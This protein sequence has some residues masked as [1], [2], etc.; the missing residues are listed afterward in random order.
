MKKLSIYCVLIVLFALTLS[1]DVTQA[2]CAMCKAV[3]QSNAGSGFGSVVDGL[4][5]GILYLMTIPYLML[6][7][8]AVVFFRKSWMAKLKK[9]QQ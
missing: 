1:P 7:I 3:T 6:S 8:L 2:Q 9:G 4:N 5:G